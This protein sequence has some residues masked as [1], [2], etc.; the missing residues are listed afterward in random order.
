MSPVLPW[1]Q[2]AWQR[3]LAAI[4]Q[5][6]LG[7]A[8][9]F[10]GPEGVGKR[11]FAEHLVARLLCNAPQPDGA[12]CGQCNACIQREAGSHP[13]VIR[14]RPE[15]GKRE[16]SV[17]V[18]RALAEKLSLSRHYQ[19]P[20]VAL[21]DPADALNT[22][23]INALLK[24]VEEPPAFT[25][26]IFI[27][28]RPQRLAPTLRSRCQMTRFGI[29]DRAQ[30]LD[31]LLEQGAT[32]AEAQ[33]AMDDGGGA[34]LAAHEWLEDEAR[35]Q[36]G[37]WRKLLSAVAQGQILPSKAA[38]DIGKDS[39]SDFLCWWQRLLQGQLKQCLLDPDTDP[40]A[41]DALVRIAEETREGR[42]HIEGNV[43]PQMVLESIFV[44][45]WRAHRG[46]ILTVT[47]NR[48]SG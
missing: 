39:S 33:Q 24:M 43:A 22:N 35:E 16:I 34:P 1:Q 48:G 46:R 5:D 47:S 23:S 20:R 17:R 31:W 10:S 25:H 29:P 32:E 26:L 7:H 42:R 13:D 41:A 11:D 3:M 14:V 6:R 9:L 15:E 44:L 4:E 36:S 40:R 12:A 37:V 30:A 38:G 28:E 19:S 8:L 2:S 27:S 45:W 18:I 21:I